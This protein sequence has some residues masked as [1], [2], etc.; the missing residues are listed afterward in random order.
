VFVGSTPQRIATLALRVMKEGTG[1]LR[2]LLTG[3][4]RSAVR[5]DTVE[6]A[7]G[8]FPSEG[9]PGSDIAITGT[10]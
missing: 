4:P 3:A 8:F 5:R 7:V 10:L 9:G 2:F 6:Q 1:D